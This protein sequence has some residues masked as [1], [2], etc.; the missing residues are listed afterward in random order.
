MTKRH[1]AV[2][3]LATAGA[4]SCSDSLAPRGEEIGAP[5]AVQFA[6]GPAADTLLS[7]A[8]VSVAGRGITDTLVFQLAAPDTVTT[9]TTVKIPAGPARFFTARG[10]SE[11]VQ[12]HEDTLTVDVTRA[13]LTLRFDLKK[14]TGTGTIETSV[15]E[16]NVAVDDST[17]FREEV[18]A[19]SAAA[20]ST[21]SYTVRVTYR[22]ASAEAGGHAKGDPVSGAVVSWAST[23]PG[24]ITV[25]STSCTTAAD[26]AC[27]ITATINSDAASGQSAGVV[28]SYKGVAH[29]VTVTVS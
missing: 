15:E 25:G 18:T 6:L 29:R 20:G 19:Q 23:N 27:S 13:N 12:T 21:L 9:T 24:T 26:G 7:G 8:V 2:A 17:S 22:N 11:H 28:A 14:L 4:A 1:L 5:V 3:A 10:Y 16:F